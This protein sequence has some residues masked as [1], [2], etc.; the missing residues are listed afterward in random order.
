MRAVAFVAIISLL[1]GC[2]PHDAHKRTIVQLIEGGTLGIGVGMQYFANTQADC[3]QMVQMGKPPSSCSGT[4]Q[5]LGS[6]GVALIIAGLVG[7]VA[8]VSTAEDDSDNQGSGS[9]SGSAAATAA[10]R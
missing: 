6:V 3:D 2:F 9:G 4:S 10:A 7:F 8:T 1:A 5:A